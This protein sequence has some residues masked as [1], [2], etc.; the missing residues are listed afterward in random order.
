MITFMWFLTVIHCTELFC[1]CYLDSVSHCTYSHIDNISYFHLIVFWKN[2]KI[3]KKKIATPYGY[4][5]F[6]FFNY[7]LV[8]FVSQLVKNCVTSHKWFA[9]Y[10]QFSMSS[11]IHEMRKQKIYVWPQKKTKTETS[12]FLSQS[13]ATIGLI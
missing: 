6:K 13:V 11:I 9:T 7:F 5:Y 3:E 4:K 8:C 2:K 12:I 10:W 1:F